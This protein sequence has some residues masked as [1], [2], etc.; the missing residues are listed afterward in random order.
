MILGFE[1]ACFWPTANCLHFIFGS[2]FCFIFS[3]AAPLCRGTV[4]HESHQR[5]L[6]QILEMS[7]TELQ[8]NLATYKLSLDI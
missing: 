7:N 5:L 6:S 2:N 1:R 4:F 3:I 8:G